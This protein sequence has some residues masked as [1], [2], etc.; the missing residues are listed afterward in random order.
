VEEAWLQAHVV[1]LIC[2]KAG[3]SNEKARRVVIHFSLIN[4]SINICNCT[5]ATRAI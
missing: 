2:E 5:S 1:G 3:A 4:L